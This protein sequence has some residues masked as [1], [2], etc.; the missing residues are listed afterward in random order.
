M[1]AAQFAQDAGPQASASFET[2]LRERFNGN[3]SHESIAVG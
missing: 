3:A 2:F 1:E